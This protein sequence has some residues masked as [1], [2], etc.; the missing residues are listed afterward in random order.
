MFFHGIPTAI[1][2]LSITY[3]F[4]LVIILPYFDSIPRESVFLYASL[5]GLS[6]A[7]VVFLDVNF[8][9]KLQ[10]ILLSLFFI[11]CGFVLCTI[12]KN[13]AKA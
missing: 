3:L 4:L 1:I 6:G 8:H 9:I 2:Y 10:I 5:V 13:K 12:I 11:I 7:S